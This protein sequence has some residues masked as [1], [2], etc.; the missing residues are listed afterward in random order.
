MMNRSKFW[1]LLN[2][3]RIHPQHHD[4]SVFASTLQHTLLQELAGKRKVQDGVYINANRPRN[5]TVLYN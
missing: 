1:P 5:G 3:H 4:D 2:E